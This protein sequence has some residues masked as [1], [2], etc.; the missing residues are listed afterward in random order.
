MTPPRFFA[1]TTLAWGA[2]GSLN[3]ARH[4][5]TATLLR[6]GR[7]IVIGGNDGTGEIALAE[8]YDP[9]TNAWSR[10]TALGGNDLSIPRQ[11][12]TATLLPDGKIMIVGGFTALGGAIA[13]NEGFDVDFSSFQLQGRFPQAGRR[14][15]HAT[16][17][18]L[19]G[20]PAAGGFDG[21]NY[22]GHEPDVPRRHA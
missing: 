22:Q 1:P 14:G 6:D 18:P 20:S 8:I 12:H 5:H 21:L 11:N 9:S 2:G 13:F 10:V 3:F 17:L 15:D 16:I 7:V 19:T 4:S